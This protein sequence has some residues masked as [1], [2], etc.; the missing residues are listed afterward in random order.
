MVFMDVWSYIYMSLIKGKKKKEKQK[1]YYNKSNKIRYKT[2]SF[3]LPD[4][5]THY[6]D[7]SP[8]MMALKSLNAGR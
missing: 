8:L 2:T 5:T 4:T 1:F 6:T 7:S 3:L